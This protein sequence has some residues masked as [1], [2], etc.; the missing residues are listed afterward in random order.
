MMV[1]VGFIAL[2]IGYQRKK[3]YP[4]NYKTKYLEILTWPIL[5]FLIL[6][7]LKQNPVQQLLKSI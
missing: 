2:K 3:G 7:F 1:T 4:V 5:L 6:S